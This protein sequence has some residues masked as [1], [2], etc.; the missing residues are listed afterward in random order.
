MLV[1]QNQ[2]IAGVCERITPIKR[3]RFIYDFIVVGGKIISVSVNIMA[4]KIK[5]IM[6]ILSRNST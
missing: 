5:K 1:A 6:A 4:I 3:P 2:K